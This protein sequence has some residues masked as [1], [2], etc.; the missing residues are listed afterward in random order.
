[1]AL[2]TPPAGFELEKIVQSDGNPC[3]GDELF[4]CSLHLTKRRQM[5]LKAAHR[6]TDLLYQAKA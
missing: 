2:G 3:V 1:V 6:G 4:L 5:L